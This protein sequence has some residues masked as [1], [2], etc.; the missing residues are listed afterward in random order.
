[1]IRSN[2]DESSDSIFGDYGDAEI[3]KGTDEQGITYR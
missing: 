1:M 2:E 3:V